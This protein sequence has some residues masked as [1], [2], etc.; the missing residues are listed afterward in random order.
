MK[1]KNLFKSS[2]I[3]GTLILTVTGI[4]SRCIGFYYKIFLSREI[5][6]DGLGM[7]QLIFP[8][9]ALFLAVSSAGIQTAIS[10]FCASCRTDR[11]AK[12][13]LAA[14]LSISVTL[15]AFC[16]L[17]IRARADWFCRIM[18]EGMDA[19]NLLLIM[20]WAI[21]LASIHSCINGYYFGR[22]K[23]MVP[24][25]SQLFEQ[26]VRVAG[27]RLFMQISLSQ[28]RIPSVSDAVWGI[29][30]GE[31]GAVLYCMTALCFFR[32]N[33]S[34]HPIRDFDGRQSRRSRFQKNIQTEQ[35]TE[36]KH[37]N[38]K[39]SF[40]RQNGLRSLIMYYKNLLS[41]AVPLTANRLIS[42]LFAS[43]ESLLIPFSLRVYGYTGTDALSVYGIL[44]GMVFSTIM[45]PAV[46]SNSLSV[47]LL[48]SISNACAK[49]NLFLIR[50]AVRRTVEICTILGFLCTFGFLFCGDW[51]G[52]HLF[53]NT[54]AGVYLKTL[55]WIC[56][57]IFLGSTLGSVLHG[58]GKAAATLAINLSAS[59]I[60]IAFIGLGIPAV[61][62]K[63]YLWGMLVSQ[64]FA[65]L[66][67]LLCI[68][69]TCASYYKKGTI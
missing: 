11:E 54:L 60:R 40:I 23:A 5:G 36:K 15:S 21:P 8:I 61:G 67:S 16:V 66:V 27:V 19:A 37:V 69:R 29:F 31:I 34:C 44:T 9:F 38:K 56:P 13:Y 55:C 47:M 22:K 4:I 65:A 58:L 50:Q 52:S 30:I 43:A 62:L 45:F 25:F 59:L 6:A 46:L 35:K 57:F 7:Y 1:E 48:P 41:M 26:I 49:K 24:A 18:M 53:E 28:G 3:S 51:I 33:Q 32:T 39:K 20:T 10:R 14:G 2:L 64:V 42:S 17:L 68:R 12:G 63:A